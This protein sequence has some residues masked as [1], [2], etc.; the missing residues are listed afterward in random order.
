MSALQAEALRAN[1]DERMQVFDELTPDDFS[2][3][4]DPS[5]K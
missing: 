5:K 3:A 1:V 2:A 4:A